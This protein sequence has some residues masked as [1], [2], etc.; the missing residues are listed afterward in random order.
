MISSF[1]ENNH[2]SNPLRYYIDRFHTG[3]VLAHSGNSFPFLK[4]MFLSL[5]LDKVPSLNKFSALPYTWSHS[6]LLEWSHIL[7]FTPGLLTMSGEIHI[8]LSFSSFQKI[9]RLMYISLRIRT[10]SQQP[11]PLNSPVSHFPFL[12]SSR[13]QFC[14]LVINIKYKSKRID[15]KT[16]ALSVK[17]YHICLSSC[18][19]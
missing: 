5:Y 19:L 4:S 9:L 16:K 13:L 18:F 7:S 11:N 10:F 1:Q 8:W 12:L 17:R 6:I 14:V 3:G 2:L 15:Q